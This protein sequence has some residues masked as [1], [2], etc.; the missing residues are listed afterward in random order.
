MHAAVQAFAQALAEERRAAM[1]ADFEALVRVQDDKRAL[2]PALREVELDAAVHRQLGEAARENVA[3]IRHL[4]AC[5][6]G[7]LGA[8]AEPSY[9]ARGEAAPS[10]PSYLRGR[11]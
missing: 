1:Q 2:L 10:A 11:L 3:L 6:K 8:Q 5:V 4:F 7:Y 9:T